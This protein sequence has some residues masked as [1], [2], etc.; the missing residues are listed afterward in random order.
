MQIAEAPSADLVVTSVTAPD[1]LVPGET[2][3]VRFTVENRGEA[4]AHAPWTDLIALTGPGLG[5]SGVA[6]EPGLGLLIDKDPVK[7][8]PYRTCNSVGCIAVA[9]FDDKL[10]SALD[11][12]EDV[13]IALASLDGRQQQ[14]AVSLKG[15]HQARSAY[16]ATEAHRHNWFWRLWS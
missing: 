3:E 13:K 15:F 14:I 8:Y 16:K 11:K 12:A 5:G 1:A 7:V 4:A 9:D 2:V 10:A 6:L